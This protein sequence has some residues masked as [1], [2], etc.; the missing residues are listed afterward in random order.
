MATGGDCGSMFV[1]DRA[2]GELVFSQR[3]DS[4]VTNCVT[5]HPHLPVLVARWVGK[6]REGYMWILYVDNNSNEAP[7][8]F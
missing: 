8:G 4:Q 6:P 5:A 2:T 1:W 3:A 7:G